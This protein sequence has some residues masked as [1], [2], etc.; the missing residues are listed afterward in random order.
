M[1]KT[2]EIRKDNVIGRV[3]DSNGNGAR[4][5][6][7]YIGR[8]DF[9]TIEEVIKLGDS[10]TTDSNGDFTIKNG[11]PYIAIYESENCEKKT[12]G[13]DFIS[14]GIVAMDKM[15]T[16]RVLVAKDSIG[17]S[18]VLQ[19]VQHWLTDPDTVFLSDKFDF[20]MI[21]STRKLPSL[22]VRH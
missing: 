2:E 19:Q 8:A 4:E 22:I 9:L 17:A 21:G 6:R 7:I 3:V 11:F 1:P 14:F 13:H 15:D 20:G 10:V 16:T 18:S 12:V 5:I